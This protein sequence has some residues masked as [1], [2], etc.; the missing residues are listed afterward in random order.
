MST[1]Q[2]RLVS[3][4]ERRQAVEQE[5]ADLATNKADSENTALV[6]LEAALTTELNKI[7]LQIGQ[8]RTYVEHIPTGPEAAP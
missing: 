3:L 8:L 4:T 1:T 2:Q 5:L 6:D 7:D